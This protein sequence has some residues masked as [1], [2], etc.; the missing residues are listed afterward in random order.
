MVLSYVQSAGTRPFGFRSA[1]LTLP[2]YRRTPSP[3][4][5]VPA[6]AWNYSRRDCRTTA[7]VVAAAAAAAAAAP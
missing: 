3:V 7:E 5:G 2:A 4:T 6:A 1:A